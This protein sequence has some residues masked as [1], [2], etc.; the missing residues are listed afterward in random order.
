MTYEEYAK[1]YIG[2]LGATGKDLDNTMEYI[3]TN[4]KEMEGRW[5]DSMD[6]YSGNVQNALRNS[7]HSNVN[8]YLWKWRLL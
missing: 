7:I 6:N 3:K 4:V 8:S 5:D 1:V 2:L